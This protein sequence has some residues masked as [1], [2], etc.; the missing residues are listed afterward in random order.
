MALHEGCMIK[1]LGLDGDLLWLCSC[2]WFLP[3]GQK[4]Q[5]WM[6]LKAGAESGWDFSS[7]WY[8]DGDGHNNGTLRDT[9]TSRI[10]PVDLN[11][12]LCRSERTLASFHRV[13]GEPLTSN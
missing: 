8:I 6:D 11:A 13:L 5:L 4:E 7:R 2:V 3:R 1:S 12:L 10:V 9:R